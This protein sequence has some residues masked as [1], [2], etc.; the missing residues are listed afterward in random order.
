MSRTKLRRS[1]PFLAVAAALTLASG[2][3]VAQAPAAGTPPVFRTTGNPKRDTVLRF[4][5]PIAINFAAT[6][7]EEVM[8]FLGE[9]TQA[10]M[11]VLWVDDKHTAGLD[12]DLEITLNFE[13][14]SALT[15]LERV[16]EKAAS[17]TTGRGGSSWQL[18][19]S[20][21]MQIGPKERLNAYKRVQIYPIADLLLEVPS[22]TNAPEFDLQRV[23]QQSQ[24]GAGGGGGGSPFRDT[25]G[26]VTPRIPLENRVNEV[27][28]LITTLV[29]PEQWTENGG[30]GGSIRPYQTNLIINAPDYLHRQIDG[31]PWWPSADTRVATVKGRRYVS[32]GTSTSNSS[33]VGFEQHPV[34]AVV[35]GTLVS[36]DPNRG[37]GGQQKPAPAAPPK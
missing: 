31:Y 28:T 37:P 36:S 16:L 8:R 18:T 23:L 26:R 7:L 17:D 24:G 27:V 20:G 14:G 34:T 2:A 5:R 12:K 15:L 33:L 4:T 35:G 30:D 25:Q 32:I 21:T 3:A 19:D 22:Y 9:I 6:R 13:R 10:D 1:F 11:E 29:E